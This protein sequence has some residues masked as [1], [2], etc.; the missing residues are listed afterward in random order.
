MPFVGQ[1]K[2]AQ[3]YNA[4]I[5]QWERKQQLLSVTRASTISPHGSLCFCAH[6]SHSQ[7]FL[8]QLSML[9]SAP[10]VVSFF[11][12]LKAKSD[13]VTPPRANSPMSSHQIQT[14]HGL[15]SPWHLLSL[16]PFSLFTWLQAFWTIWSWYRPRSFW[17][18]P[19][20]LLFHQPQG[21]FLSIT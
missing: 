8:F 4:I 2:L 10:R 9:C 13:D 3:H 16:T 7:F 21:L 5:P 1:Q 6:P 19:V 17:S 18:L 12:S 20:N 14:S 11:F 15:Q